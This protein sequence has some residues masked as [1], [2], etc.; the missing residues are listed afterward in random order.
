[1][2]RERIEEVIIDALSDYLETQGIE[3]EVSSDTVLL[4]SESELDSM[5][6]VNVV[7][8]VES[9]FQDQG[10]SISLASEKAMSRKNSPFRTVSTLTDFILELIEEA[11]K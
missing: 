3:G 7:I 8:D 4:G 2:E 6:V 10:Y 11:P 9:H 1:M 5:G